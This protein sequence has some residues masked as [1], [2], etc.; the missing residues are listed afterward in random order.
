ML[1]INVAENCVETNGILSLMKKQT[2][3]FL[4]MRIAV[5]LYDSFLLNNTNS[6]SLT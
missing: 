1:S 6:D 2:K 4:L 5:A 3:K